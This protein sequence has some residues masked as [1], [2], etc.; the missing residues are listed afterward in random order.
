M[1]L[2]PSPKLNATVTGDTLC[3]RDHRIVFEPV[4]FPVGY[5][6]MAVSPKTKA[7]VEK[8]SSALSR[9]VEED[10]SLRVTREPD[11]S[12]TPCLRLG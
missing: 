4:K 12:E 9:I 2:G 10:P 6:T 3:Q 5:Y 8:M 11:T 7:D 1:T